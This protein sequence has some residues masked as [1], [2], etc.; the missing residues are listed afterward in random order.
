MRMK[1]MISRAE[2]RFSSSRV[3]A[4]QYREQRCDW[5][6]TVAGQIRRAAVR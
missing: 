6:E 2:D 4:L 1:P 3:R 5:L